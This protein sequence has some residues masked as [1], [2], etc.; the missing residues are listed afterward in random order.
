[1]D[2]EDKNG[3]CKCL[4]YSANALARNITKMA[5]NEFKHLGLSPSYVF[6]LMTILK[7][8]GILAGDIAIRM[9]LTPSTVTRLLEKLESK[10]LLIRV[11]EG[12]KTLV[13]PSESANKLHEL[14]FE[15]WN[16]LFVSYT[17][18]LGIEFAQKLTDDIF[19]SA[20]VLEQNNKI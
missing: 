5:E 4:Y 17:N 3:Y 10:E 9:M 18:L 12:R 19:A 7:N 14:I 6:I 2:C 11:T 16:K 1:M 13:Y 15:A 20:L 8:P